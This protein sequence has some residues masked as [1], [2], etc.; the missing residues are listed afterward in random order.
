[1]GEVALAGQP[2]WPG[3]GLQELQRYKLGSAR[4]WL[5]RGVGEGPGR[6][7]LPLGEITSMVGAKVP[8]WEGK[9]VS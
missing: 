1:M 5:C 2:T 6:G 8:F 4:S 3:D 7:E 9:A